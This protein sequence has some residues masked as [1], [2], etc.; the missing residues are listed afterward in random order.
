MKLL[1]EPERI[2]R[3]LG[4]VAGLAYSLINQALILAQKDRHREAHSAADVLLMKTV[5]VCK[6]M[7]MDK[8]NTGWRV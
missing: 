7:D 4:N 5:T 2:W 6:D 8:R 1:K 3:E